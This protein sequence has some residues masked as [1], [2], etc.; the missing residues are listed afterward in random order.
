[1]ILVDA[2]MPI[3]CGVCRFPKV[4]ICNRSA[5]PDMSGK[6]KCPIIAEIPNNATNGDV[7]CALWNVSVVY[8]NG[9]YRIIRGGEKW[10]SILKFSEEWWN[11][12][13]KSESDKSADTFEKLLDSGFYERF[14]K[15]DNNADS[16]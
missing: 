12:P 4:E 10:S 11:A 9:C 15:E 5:M 7:I 13:Y 8:E 1:M 3:R 2:K 16:D 6:N 14:R